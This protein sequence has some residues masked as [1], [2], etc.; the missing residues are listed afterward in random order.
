MVLG[1]EARAASH[2]HAHAFQFAHDHAQKETQL[3][4]SEIL[5]LRFFVP[6]FMREFGRRDERAH[7]VELAVDGGVEEVRDSATFR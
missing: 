3:H 2:K 4:S 1:I 5:E 6:V 7:L